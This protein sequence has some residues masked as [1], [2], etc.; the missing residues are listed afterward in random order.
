MD[1]VSMPWKIKYTGLKLGKY[2]YLHHDRILFNIIALSPCISSITS[3]NLKRTATQACVACP[4][5]RPCHWQVPLSS[6]HV[7]YT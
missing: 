3:D 5:P 4:C 7:A 2:Y 1:H 6:P